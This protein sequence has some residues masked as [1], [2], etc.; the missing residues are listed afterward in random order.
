VAGLF[1]SCLNSGCL[2]QGLCRV[3]TILADATESDA[4][5]GVEV[6]VLDEDVGAV[7]LH[8]DAVVAIVDDP[9]AEGNVVGVDGVGSV[10]LR[11]LS[12]LGH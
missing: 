8:R 10:S 11:C 6:T 3:L 1:V 4:E 2:G 9:V 7:R 12:E 5:A